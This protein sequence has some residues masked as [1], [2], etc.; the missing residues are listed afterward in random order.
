MENGISLYPGLG[1]SF[2]DNLVLLETAASYGIKRIFTSFHIP[3]TDFNKF[4]KQFDQ[5]MKIVSENNMEIISDISPAA[6]T[7]LGAKKLNLS[8]FC[9]K[10]IKRLRLDYGYDSNIISELSHNHHK[11][12]LQLNAST[13]TP[14]L[15]NDLYFKDADFSRI[16]ALHNFY[17]RPGTGLS[18]DFF[19][20]KT[21][22]LHENS[23]KVG[24]FIPCHPHCRPPLKKGLPTLEDHRT[25]AF[26]LAA[27]HLCAMDV[28]SIFVGDCL[29]TEKQLQLLA[30]LE[31]NTV[32]IK[33]KLFT[34]NEQIKTLL[35]QKFTSR[36]DEAR[37][38][39]RTQESRNIFKDISITPENTSERR[40]GM[41]TL[42][43]D[44]YLRYK[45][46]LQIIKNLQTADEKV[47]VIGQI[48]PNELFL[49]QYITAGK[50][51]ILQFED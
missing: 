20:N 26:S 4:Q 22:I 31:S 13:I 43:N 37:D 18:L 34:K 6:L 17:P 11:I 50:S 29:P 38:A 45:G 36:I 2:E 28:D 51:F 10:G 3:E 44:E 5:M 7:L 42:D 48:L 1:N 15:L 27:R 16:D 30:T 39:I 19:H 9:I 35:Q 32:I 47:N 25:M 49:M 33:A 40:V 21:Q 24:A 14:E 8:L 12:N 46:E 41:I 23:I